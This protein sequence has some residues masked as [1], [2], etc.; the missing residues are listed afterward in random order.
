MN[1]IKIVREPG[2][3]VDTKILRGAVQLVLEEK[4]LFLFTEDSVQLV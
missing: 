4:Y 3:E 2:L 1:D